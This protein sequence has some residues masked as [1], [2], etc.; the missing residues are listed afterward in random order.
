[1]RFK[2]FY[3]EEIHDG[4]TYRREKEGKEIIEWGREEEKMRK[5]ML[6]HS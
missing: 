6:M 3:R 1:M 2:R 4:K 5:K